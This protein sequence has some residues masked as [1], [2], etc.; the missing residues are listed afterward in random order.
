MNRTTFRLSVRFW[1]IA[2]MV[3]PALGMAAWAKAPE[4]PNVL[5]IAVDDLNDWVGFLGGHPQVKTPNMDRLAKRGMAFANAQCAAPLCSPSRAA[6]F[7]GKQPFHTGVYGNSDSILTVRPNQSSSNISEYTK[8]R[9]GKL[10]RGSD[11]GSMT[12]PSL[13][14]PMSP[15]AR[16]Q[17]E[18]T[19]K[20]G[21]VPNGRARDRTGTGRKASCCRS[22]VCRATV[23]APGGEH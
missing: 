23:R 16:Q 11:R 7:S 18:Y 9:T 17:V 14:E 12:S 2:C 19:A 13:A 8:H 22:T 3:T 5:F 15:F 1:A 6:V 4:R 10:L 20:R 21:K